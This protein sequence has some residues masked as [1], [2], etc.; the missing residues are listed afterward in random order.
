MNKSKTT[1]DYHKDAE[2]FGAI[3]RKTKL[4]DDSV[5]FGNFILK[6]KKGIKDRIQ[7]DQEGFELLKK[8]HEYTFKIV[9][10]YLQVS[11]QL[12]ENTRSHYRLFAYT[13]INGKEGM[14]FSVNLT[15]EK[16]TKNVIYLT[17]KIKFTEQ[18]DGNEN[19]AKAHRRQKQIVFCNILRKLGLVV[20]ENNDIALGIFDPTTSSFENTS[21]EGF[22]NDFIVVSLLKGHFMGNKGYALEILPSFDKSIEIFESLD[23]ELKEQLPRKISE[24]KGKRTIPLALRYIVLKR[25]NSKCVRCGRGPDKDNGIKLHVDHKIPFSLGGLTTLDNLQ[26]L[27]Q[28]CNLGKSNKHIDE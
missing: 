6:G 14:T 25:D 13:R 17:Q 10:G 7:Y 23:E 21:P 5:S 11:L 1:L 27:C 26:T 3:L 19:L 24:Q 28:E 8:K 9:D 2:N 4:I 20:D 15:T 16:E 12:Y 18:Y 22:L